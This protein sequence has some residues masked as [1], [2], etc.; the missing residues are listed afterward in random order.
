MENMAA[1]YFDNSPCAARSN[2]ECVDI[3]KNTEK[4]FNDMEV[5]IL[6]LIEEDNKVALRVC[7]TVTHS[8]EAYGIQPNGKRISFE[9]LEIFR[10]ENG[11]IAESWGYWLD[12][13]IKELLSQNN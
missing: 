10:I 8:A 7:F 2:Q 12:M 11:L 1:D 5:E 6:D 13:N 4:T 9:A 3:L